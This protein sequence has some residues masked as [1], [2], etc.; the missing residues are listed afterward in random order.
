ME[1]LIFSGF[2]IGASTF[3][4]TINNFDIYNVNNQYF[5]EQVSVTSNQ[6]FD[7]LTAIWSELILGLKAE[8]L[9]NLFMGFNIQFKI[10]VSEDEPNNFENLYIP[11]FNRTYDSGNFGFGFGYNLQYLIPIFK[12]DK[13]VIEDATESDN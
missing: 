9:N 4:H 8:V 3:S 13:I 2:R 6:E 5:D 12:K 1:N 11:G 10:L 7:G